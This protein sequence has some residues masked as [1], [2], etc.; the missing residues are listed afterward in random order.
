MALH[1]RTFHIIYLNFNDLD[2]VM[3]SDYQAMEYS[4]MVIMSG[5][6]RRGEGE[7][8]GEE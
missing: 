1:R 5:P 8:E 3:V 4:I 7:E 6:G 2:V